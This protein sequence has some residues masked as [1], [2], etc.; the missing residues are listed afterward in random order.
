MLIVASI[1]PLADWVRQV[2][3]EYVQVATLLK[4]G[5][6]PHTYEPT[7]EDGMLVA[8]SEGLVCVGLGLEEW[9]AEIARAAGKE[10]ERIERLGE[11][12]D[13][14][15]LIDNDPHVWLDP[16]LAA[17]M[18]KELARWLSK[19]DPPHAQHYSQAAEDYVAKLRELV[20]EYKEK[21]ASLTKPYA[22]TYHSA[23]AYMFRRFGIQLLG[24]IEPQPGKEPSSAD[25]AML[26]QKMRQCSVNVVFAEPQFSRKA[27]DAVAG[28]LGA[29]VVMLDPI[30]N[31]SDPD[32]DTYINLMRYNL[33]A[34][35]SALSRQPVQ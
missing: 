20:D 22:V 32:R 3:G 7:P 21:F 29:K 5:S 17:E 19:L 34:I 8:Q 31:P 16:L 4:P 25:I 18:V 23:F 6:S 28:E 24:V 10:E 14:E 12:L 35:L 30:G 15:Q 1:H 27:A 9:I 11:S 26:V 33:D 13:K 2:G